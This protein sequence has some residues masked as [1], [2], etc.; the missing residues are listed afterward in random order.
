MSFWSWDYRATTEP[1]IPSVGVSIC[2]SFIE[3]TDG[4]G[5][6]RHASWQVGKEVEYDDE[7]G[8]N[9]VQSRL[10]GAVGKRDGMVC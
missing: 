2:R 3:A 10:M 1:M 7:R 5:E 8:T 9:T 4:A 6:G